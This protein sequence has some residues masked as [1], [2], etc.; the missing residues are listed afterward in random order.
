MVADCDCDINIATYCLTASPTFK[1]GNGKMFYLVQNYEPLFFNEPVF[2]SK[3]EESYTLPLKKLCVSRW[4][5]KKVGGV[6]IGNGVNTQVFHPKNAFDEKEPC[7]VLYLYRGIPWKGDALAIETLEH[8][9]GS[10]PNMKVHLVSRKNT[11]IKANFPYELHVDVPDEELAHL[12][13]QVRVLLFTSS[14]EGYGLPPLEALACGTNVVSTNFMG[15]EYLINGRN[16][17][18]A[19]EATELVHAISRLIA[20]DDLSLSQ[21][22]Q[23]AK[24]VKMHDFD[25]VVEKVLMAFNSY[26]EA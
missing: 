8:L 11:S 24:T 4:L 2:A 20:D 7:S 14:F 26:R 5:Q 9:Y 1:S 21:L 16:C 22:E 18:L 25:R 19:D 17:I 12:Y 10:N 6:Y 3:A 23:A 15:N 13:S